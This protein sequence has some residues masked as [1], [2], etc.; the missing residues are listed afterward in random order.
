MPLECGTYAG[1]MWQARQYSH[2][3]LSLVKH[4]TMYKWIIGKSRDLVLRIIGGAYILICD[5]SPS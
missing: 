3:S 4:K 1:G 5:I 2:A